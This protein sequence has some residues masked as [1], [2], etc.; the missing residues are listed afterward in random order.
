MKHGK[1]RSAVV[2]ALCVASLCVA[3][4]SAQAAKATP[5]TRSLKINTSGVLAQLDLGAGPGFTENAV[6]RAKLNRTLRAQRNR[7]L[8]AVKSVNTICTKRVAASRRA[9]DAAMRRARTTLDRVVARQKFTALSLQYQA[10]REAAVY[11][12]FVYWEVQVNEA[13]RAFDASTTTADVLA[14]RRAFRDRASSAAAQLN[15]SVSAARANFRVKRSAAASS[16]RASLSQAGSSEDRAR[17]WDAY[18][19]AVAAAQREALATRTSAV[20]ALTATLS[21]A[22]DEYEVE[23]EE[24]SGPDPLQPE[25]ESSGAATP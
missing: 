12:A 6:A 7:Y 16:L 22:H 3:P 19:S 8:S 23:V 24:T 25:P 10:E 18:V 20:P 14:A 4:V 13:F 17:A 1:V 15:A 9:R 11:A 21:E 2:A 5:C